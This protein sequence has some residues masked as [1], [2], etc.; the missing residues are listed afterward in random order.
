MEK[1]IHL[2]FS[3][4]MSLF[5][6]FIMSFVVTFVHVGFSDELIT[7][8]LHGFWVAWLVG[9]PLMFFFAPIFRKTI[10]KKL[11]KNS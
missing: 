1:K 11:T 3:L 5:M 7:K 8:W 6:I 9:F 4:V 2:I 10:T